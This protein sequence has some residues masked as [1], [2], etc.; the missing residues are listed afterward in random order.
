MR[1][2]IVSQD[3]S[4][5]DPN[6]YA[7]GPI[8][9]KCRFLA[10]INIGPQGMQRHAPLAVPFGAGN[11]RSAQ[12][13]TAIDPNTLSAKAYCRLDSAL[14]GTPK[15]DAALKLLCNVLGDQIG[16]DLRLADLEKY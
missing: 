4:L 15:G 11:F 8:S 2:R 12:A 9:R 16:I 14:H 3:F 10:V 13:A 5:E 6:L 1:H 7:T